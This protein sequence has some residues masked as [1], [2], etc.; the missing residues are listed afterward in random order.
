MNRTTNISH[1]INS[2]TMNKVRDLKV[3]YIYNIENYAIE[4]INKFLDKLFKKNGICLDDIYNNNKIK[5][6]INLIPGLYRKVKSCINSE[7]VHIILNIYINLTGNFPTI[8]TLLICNEE[9]SEEKINSFLHRALFCKKPIL[10]LIVNLEYLELAIIQY[11]FETLKILYKEKRD[12]INSYIIFLYEKKDIF[13]MREIENL[14]PEKNILNNSFLSS[15]QEKKEEFQKIEVYSSKFT[16]Y[17]KTTEIKYKI[18]NL[19]GK[20]NYLP[21]RGLISRNDII[22]HFEKLD[23]DLNLNNGK[24]TYLHIDLSEMNNEDLMNEILFKIIILRYIDSKEKIFYL[25]NDIHLIL[26]IP[27]DSIEFDKKYKI[28]NLFK[29]IYIEKLNPLRLEEN[30]KFI[31]DSPISIVAE[32][33]SLY[34]NDEIEIKNIDLFSPVKKSA[35]ECEKIINKYLK[36]ENQNYYTKLNLIKILSYLF[37]KFTNN[38]YL[39][40]KYTEYDCNKKKIKIMRKALIKNFIELAKNLTHFPFFTFNKQQKNISAKYCEN[41][42]IIEEMIS[43]LNENRDIFSFQHIT[44]NL[45]IFHKD[46]RSLSII[47]NNKK[48][49]LEYKIFH[50]LWNL[51]NYDYKNSKD[52]I[53]YKNLN[54]ETVLNLIKNIFSLDK[55]PINVIKQLCINLGDFIFVPDNLI[56]IVI[57]LLKIEAK[58]PVILMGETGTGKTK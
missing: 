5:E 44:S 57:I 27:N 31:K 15:Y 7:Y 34:D 26:E 39:N 25:G 58:I 18:K 21:I 53:D 20:Y 6:D 42:V 56:K 17:G 47:S 9:T 41:E 14:I 37:I 1:L 54:L 22:N 32:V 55:F 40:F 50:S 33:L 30:I 28:L 23:L 29:K 8:N 4:N 3:K 36:E 46:G 38:F 49:D 13:I 24:S 48:N 35:E 10:F 12:N 52:L 16:G 19:D 11:F 43:S 45:V 51:Q 2:V